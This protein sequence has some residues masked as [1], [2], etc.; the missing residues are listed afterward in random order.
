MGLMRYKKTRCVQKK[1]ETWSPKC[2]V[3][4]DK[5]Q[6]QRTYENYQKYFNSNIATT[7]KINKNPKIKL[8]KRQCKKKYQNHDRK[9]T[10]A[11]K[12]KK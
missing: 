12:K 7:K 6:I 4:K 10:P 1:H 2:G 9:K 3:K 11:K 5:R 8:K